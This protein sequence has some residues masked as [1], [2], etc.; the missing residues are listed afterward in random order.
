[1]NGDLDSS[2]QF[3]VGAAGPCVVV[4]NPPTSGITRT[5]AL[6]LAAWLVAIADALD[7][8]GPS[9]EQVLRAVLST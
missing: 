1:M 8:E 7:D 6:N 3:L 4:L 9:F 2:N 5:Q